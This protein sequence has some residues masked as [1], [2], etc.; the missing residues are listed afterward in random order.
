[1]QKVISEVHV[2]NVV[3]GVTK[4]FM[5]C[6]K[7]ISDCDKAVSGERKQFSECKSA[8]WGILGIFYAGL[9]GQN[10]FPEM[11]AGTFCDIFLPPPPP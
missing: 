8:S 6:E 7:Q 4:Q 9:L 10:F 5:E 11:R 2:Y 1:M 3:F